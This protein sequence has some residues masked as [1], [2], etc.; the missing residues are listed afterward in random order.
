[1]AYHILHSTIE[2]AQIFYKEEEKNC[3]KIIEKLQDDRKTIESKLLA[4]GYH[5]W[6]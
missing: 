2:Y 4:H 3:G 6:Q 5:Q 1:M